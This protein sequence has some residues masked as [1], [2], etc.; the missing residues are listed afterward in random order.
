MKAAVYYGPGDMRIEER[1]K[2]VTGADGVVVKVKDCGVC[3][4]IDL[5]AW[6]SID[7]M[8]VGKI[9][10][11]EWSGEIVE[12]GPNVTG[13]AVGDRVYMEPIFK[14]CYRCEA[15]LQKDY[16]RCANPMHSGMVEGAFAEYQWIPFTSEASLAKLP[17]TLS[18]RD[19]ALVEP[20]GLSIGIAKKT[21][22]GDTVVVLGQH[23]VGLG[24]TAYLKNKMDVGKVITTS[25]SQKHLQASEEV[26]ADIALNAIND[27]VVKTVMQETL[28]RGA[29]H[30]VVTDPRPAALLQGIGAVRR[31]GCVW[32]TQYGFPIRLGGALGQTPRYSIG[33]DW[34]GPV[35][36]PVSFEPGLL[37]MRSAWG[38]MGER[39]PRFQ[40][41][42][43]LMESGV[44]TAEKYVTHIFPLEETKEAF[45]KAMDFNECIEV[46]VEL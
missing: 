43:A 21:K 22:P 6:E 25:I 37:Y 45:D 18:F 44:I 19:L 23:L 15:C 4:F 9:R 46:M 30:V 42:V 1:P 3:G 32:L 12:V 13:F 33:L 31:T 39:V 17:D 14:P 5:G 29:D 8:G 26:G 38:V 35:E 28:G 2:P 7:T 24:I 11:H 16:W 10:G 36:P 20:L 27:D 40:E 34:H 41:A